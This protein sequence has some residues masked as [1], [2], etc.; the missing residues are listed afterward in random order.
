MQ[1][2]SNTFCGF[3]I[4]GTNQMQHM[5]IPGEK[6][7]AP[8][9]WWEIELQC[10]DDKSIF[11]GRH[12]TSSLGQFAQKRISIN[13]S[14]QQLVLYWIFLNLYFSFIHWTKFHWQLFTPAIFVGLNVQ[15]K[16]NINYDSHIRQ[17]TFLQGKTEIIQSETEKKR[18]RIEKKERSA[19]KAQKN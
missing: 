13:N 14:W 9:A 6:M 8:E 16:V 18:R 5:V 10:P 4:L 15:L 12:H 3:L 17:Q 2:I 19:S 11:V 1:N 7:T